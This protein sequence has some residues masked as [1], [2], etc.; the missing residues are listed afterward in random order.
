MVQNPFRPGTASVPPLLAGRDRVLDPVDVAL[1]SLGNN[2]GSF[3][4][5]YGPRGLGKTSVLKAIESRA[6][7][8]GWEC[9]SHEVRRDAPLLRPLLDK[10]ASTAGLP[11]RIAAKVTATREAWSEQEQ[12][13]DLKIYRRTARRTAVDL[14]ITDQFLDTLLEIV[15]HLSER[16]TGLVLLVDEVHNADPAELSILGPTVQRLSAES[17]KSAMIALAGLSSV[18]KHLSQAFT[19]SERWA[20]HPLDNLTVGDAALALALPARQAGKAFTV[21]AVDLAAELSRGYPFAVQLL[22][23]NAWNIAGGD[24]ITVDDVRAANE[25]LAEQLASG[26]YAQRWTTVSALAKAYLA[27]AAHADNRPISTSE[28]C[29]ALGR[30]PNQL[31]STRAVLIAAGT[32]TSTSAGTIEEAIPGF[33]DYVRQQPDSLESVAAAYTSRPSARTGD[34]HAEPRLQRPLSER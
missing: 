28:I 18:P 21:G 12:T 27:A 16:A 6:G 33:F 10:L 3:F 19:Y 1:A 2:Y 9:V 15:E 25:A 17:D 22:G 4:A 31:S 11:S 30:Q 14:P 34:A 7:D 29:D 5:V 24:E 8:A 32:I 13:I 23:F 26:L 20:F